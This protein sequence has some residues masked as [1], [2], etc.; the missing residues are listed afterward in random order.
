MSLPKI[1][2]NSIDYEYYQ[3]QESDLLEDGFES[4]EQEFTDYY[5]KISLGDVREQIIRMYQLRIEGEVMGYV[6]VAAAHI[7]NDATP[8]IEAKEICTTVPALLISHLAVK[9]GNQRRGIGRE[10]LD[11]VF[12]KILPE[13]KNRVGCRY[14]MLNPRDDPTVHEF[15][16]AYGF[17]YYENA[18]DDKESDAFLYDLLKR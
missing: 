7:R 9:K 2:F 5:H 18:M 17:E 3:V 14:V 6:T 15:Y 13:I 1:D 16:K 8:A 10:L 11:M 12:V 4:N